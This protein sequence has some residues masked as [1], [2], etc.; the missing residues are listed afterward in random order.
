MIRAAVVAGVLALSLTACSAGSAVQKSEAGAG[1]PSTTGTG[2]AVSSAAPGATTSAISSRS[3]PGATTPAALGPAGGP[4][5]PGFTPYSATFVSAS[6]GWVLGSAP[7]AKA[8][9]GSVVRTTDGGRSWTGIP[10]PKA[11]VRSF[12]ALASGD[13]SIL[14]FAD[15]SNGWAAGRGIYATHDGGAKW[16]PVRVG[17]ATGTVLSL[18]TGGG[19]VYALIQGCPPSG[20]GA[21]PK[22]VRVYAAKVGSDT[23]TPVSAVLSGETAQILVVHGS[24]WYLGTSAGVLWASGTSKPATRFG[25]CSTGGSGPPPVLAVADAQHLDALCPGNGAAGSTE[26]QL[27]GSTDAG[28][29]WTKAG[30]QR[31]MVPD[32]LTGMADNAHGVLLISTASGTSVIL[33]S[34]DDGRTLADASVSAPAGGFPWADLGFT[35]TE[36]AAVTLPGH[37]FYLSHDAGHSWSRVSF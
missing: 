20:E 22:S 2:S 7:C 4:V 8:P 27:Y 1:T 14:R 25:P 10:A 6:D 16:Q 11:S 33:R 13:V 29:R 28:Q 32:Q 31:R 23:W 3:G 12:K 18:E 35:T 17:P 37:G 9:C 21:C 36:Q 26:I 19:W 15:R 24:T 30:P 5:P 34:T